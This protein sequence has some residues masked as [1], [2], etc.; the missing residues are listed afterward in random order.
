MKKYT[1]EQTQEL[2]EVYSANPSRETVDELAAKYNVT[3]R[4]II[5]K[6][7]KMGIYQKAEYVPKYADKPVS[8]EELV[9]HIAHQLDVDPEKLA[10]LSKSQK[11]ALLYL[12]EILVAN[13]WIDPRD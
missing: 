8:K 11:P 2:Q 10:G 5:G 12:E 1:D 4:S 3:P 9:L 7:S 6:L 13:E